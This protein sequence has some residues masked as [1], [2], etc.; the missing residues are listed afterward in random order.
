MAISDRFST[1]I[2]RLAPTEAEACRYMAHLRTVSSRIESVLPSNRTE[3]MGS[4]ARGTALRGFSD[5][6]LLAVLSVKEQR[7]TENSTTVLRKLK[8][9]LSGRFAATEMRKDGCAVVVFFAAGDRP[10]DVVPAFYVG[11][12]TQFRNY[13]IFRIPDGSGGWLETSPQAHR[14]YLEAENGRSGGKLRRLALLAKYWGR[15][16]SNV[17]LRSFH[18]ELVIAANGICVGPRSYGEMMYDFF[19]ILVNRSGHGIR[20]PLGISGV[21]PATS[22]PSA[23]ERLVAAAGR[24]ADHAIRALE[25]EDSRNTQEAV[26]RWKV[27]FGGDFP[28]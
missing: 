15:C 5:L 8:A 11:P 19:R 7:W 10:V 25:A 13:P 18:V 6:D 3:T 2:E 27:I 23:R 24:S 26:R 14:A 28:S 12:A 21:I 22:G 17:I 20:D 1:L 9:T 4:F 16:H